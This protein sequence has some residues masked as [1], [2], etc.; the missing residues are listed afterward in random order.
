MPPAASRSLVNPYIAGSAVSGAEMFFGREDVFAFIRRN[1]IGRHSN[2]TVVLYGQRR[3]G[4]TSV[5]Y[6]L[7]R[8]LD[9]G[10]WCVFID[11]HGL[12]LDGLGNFMQGIATAISRDLR[13]DHQVTVEVPERSAFL[14]DPAAAFERAFLDQVWAAIGDNQLVLMLDE[15]VRLDE[16]IRA[17]RL[18]RGVFDYLRHLM[19]HNERLNFVFSL[20]SGIE[21]LSRDYAFLFSVSL[22]H[23]ISFLEPSAARDLI[24]LPA[25]GH[26]ELTEQAVGRILQ[27]TSA[28]AYY[29]QLVCHCVFD[30]WA[31]NPAATIGADDVD[32]ALAEAVELGSA[33]LTYVWLDSSPAEQVLMAGIATATQGGS[34]AVTVD[35]ARQA[36]RDAGVDVPDHEITRALRGLTGREVI[37]GHSAYS[38][39]VDL[40]RL[41]LARHRRLD[42]VKDDLAGQIAQWNAPGLPAGTD[43]HAPQLAARTSHNVHR[44]HRVRIE[45]QA[46]KIGRRPDN[47]IVV[48]DLGVS[49]RHAELRRS[50]AGRYSIIDLGSHNGTFVN[51]SR[52]NQAEL[53][54][55]DIIAVGHAVFQ[56]A[57]GELTEYIDDGRAAFEAYNLQLAV[58]DGGKQKI[59]LDG[60]TFPLPERSMMAV[61]GPAGAGKSMLLNALTGKRPATS[62]SIFY[63]SRDLY[64]NYDELR[65]LIGLVP[66]ELIAHDQLTVR[67]TLDYTAELRFPPDVTAAERNL[68]VAEVLDQ[69]GMTPHADTRIKHLADDQRKFLSIGLELLTSPSLLFLDEPTSL[70]D[71]G[72]KHDVFEQLRKMADPAAP[73]GQ[74]VIVIT[75]DVE[76]R[77]LGTC[78]RILVLAPG[79]TMAFYGPPQEGL[80]YFRAADWADAFSHFRSSGA[81]D[82]AGE[83]LNSPEYVKY[84]AAP[85]SARPLQRTR[86]ELQGE[87]RTPQPLRQRGALTQAMTMARRYLRV[88]RADRAFLITATL[89][90]IILGILVL[91]T[92]DNLGLVNGTGLARGANTTAI[93]VL[94]IL[95]LSSVLS[96][97]ALSIREFIKERDIYQRERMAGLSA[98]AYLLSKVI[99]L[100]VISVLQT[101]IVVIVGVGELKVPARGVVIPGT[102]LIEIFAV[103]AMLGVTS[104]LVGLAISTLFTKRDQAMPILVI[105]TMVQVA[106]SG[107]LFPVTGA[108][109]AISLIAPARWGLGA[110]A[111]TIN[112]NALQ[113]T[114]TTAQGE[115]PP[116]QSPDALWTHDASHW[117]AAMAAMVIIGV[118]WLV[119]ARTRLASA[120]SRKRK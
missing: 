90:P 61:I 10:Y 4:K 82:W 27:I 9:P 89:M 7:H 109:N 29:T 71:P 26:Y 18:D 32:D 63:D 57:G 69:L 41:W 68:R 97:T 100:S 105:V 31:R 94:M 95:V 120:D 80:R 11:L 6:Q 28:H 53:S 96:G 55:G 58:N 45:A 59:M 87:D 113:A 44:P 74:S 81:R 30:A 35:Q 54:E 108:L 86:P 77:L 56:L 60:I 14:A 85:L 64:D 42:W 92:P 78:D 110:L 8:H 79:G 1:L 116:V 70:L 48:A 93:Q 51:G 84:V 114:V 65:R 46:M 118:I 16:E 33:N 102:A 83:F 101:L 25:R 21:E 19:Q 106:L 34:T 111:S 15:A 49:K 43:H 98:A 75:R 117:L 91:S 73:A 103:L 38:F 88:M 119:I 20:G 40:Q 39:T 2:H 52:V 23:R 99:V 115:L 17:G 107:G 22:Y 62:G 76:S 37:T 24:T 13:R 72:L 3:T 36:W 66:Q 12:N 5:L 112:L 47:D 67:A 50:A 104:M